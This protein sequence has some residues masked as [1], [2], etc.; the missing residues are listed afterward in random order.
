MLNFKPDMNQFSDTS[1]SMV[2]DNYHAWLVKLNFG[3]GLSLMKKPEIALAILTKIPIDVIQLKKGQ[4][5]AAIHLQ[6]LN[7]LNQL[8][9]QARLIQKLN[10][11]HPKIP[12]GKLHQ[13]T[14]VVKDQVV[15]D[16]VVKD[17][18]DS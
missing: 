12:S 7:H 11:K 14:K 6:K 9:P 10:L 18:V 15:K 16:Q 2:R 8:N 17:Q 4:H 1:D 13:V 5:L 3:V